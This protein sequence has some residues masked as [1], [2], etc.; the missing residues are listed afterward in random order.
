M[1]GQRNHFGIN[2]E[3]MCIAEFCIIPQEAMY[4]LERWM[5][6]AGWVGGIDFGRKPEMIVYMIILF[7]IALQFKKKRIAFQLTKRKARVC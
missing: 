5:E 6:L 4:Q 3:S 2:D 7:I 1:Q